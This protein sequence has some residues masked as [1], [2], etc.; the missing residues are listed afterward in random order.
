MPESNDFQRFRF[1]TERTPVADLLSRE[2]GFNPLTVNLP[3]IEL[4]NSL[5]TSSPQNPISPRPANVTELQNLLRSIPIAVPGAV[6]SSEYHNALR[7]AVMA[8]GQA[9]GVTFASPFDVVS[10]TPS[11]HT[12]S[13]GKKGWSIGPARAEATGLDAVTG[14]QSVSLPDGAVVKSMIVRGQ[15]TKNLKSLEVNLRRYPIGKTKGPGAVPAT[16]LT[17]KVSNASGD[18][19]TD[20]SQED[21]PIDALS[22]NEKTLAGVNLPNALMER[23]RIDNT[24]YRYILEAT[25]TFTAQSRSPDITIDSIQI[26]CN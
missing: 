11:F 15:R 19:L 6:I 24:Q 1:L 26:R 5:S 25:A 14:W 21:F 18:E 7:G 23:T 12:P 22:E 16:I 8:L 17:T 9:L 10:L 20:Y 4:P 13:D 3:K 2:K